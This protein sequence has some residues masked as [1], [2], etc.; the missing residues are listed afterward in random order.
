MAS[1]M[2]PALINAFVAWKLSSCHILICPSAKH[3]CPGLPSMKS[4]SWVQSFTLL[5]K[6]SWVQFISFGIKIC[7]SD[8]QSYQAFAL[9]Q[10]TQ[11][12]VGLS[13]LSSWPRQKWWILPFS[14]YVEPEES[15]ATAIFQNQGKAI[16]LWPW[17]LPSYTVVSALVS[18]FLIGLY[19]SQV[20]LGASSWLRAHQAWLYALSA[21]FILWLDAWI[22]S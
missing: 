20:S 15:S 17:V 9:S 4:L 6:K 11:Y 1:H 10:F 13:R 22:A 5:M 8:Q 21:L 18:F 3:T 14:M 16:F 7:S 12:T 19:G 2:T